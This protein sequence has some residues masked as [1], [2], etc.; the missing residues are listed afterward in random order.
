M[1]NKL[2]NLLGH[3]PDRVIGI[4]IGTGV[5]KLAELENSQG[6]PLLKSYGI[7]DL[8]ENAI[9][10]GRIVDRAAVADALRK[11]ISTSGTSCRDAVL[12][13]SGR[14]LFVREIAMPAMTPVELREAIKWELD[15]YVPYPAESCYF[16]FAILGSGQTETELRI[17]LVIV[18]NERVDE[19]VELVKEVGLRPIAIDIE[20]LAL[21]RTLVAAE[22]SMVIDIGAM[23]SQLIVF[24]GG[25][26]AV[27]RSIPVGG[28]RFTEVVMNVLELEYQEAERLKQ[29][30]A[31]LLQRVDIADDSATLHR[32]LHLLVAEIARE[33]RRT[34]E[35]YQIQNRGSTI[36]R[37]IVTG[38]GVRLNNLAEHLASMLDAEVVVHDPLAG[39]EIA[40]SFD[41]QFTHGNGPQ[42]AVALGLSL[43]GGD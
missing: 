27:T 36:D 16:D 8:A 38:G 41:K 30:Q 11:L 12:A 39:I 20:P 17:L 15:K 1:W 3:K 29:R 18:P 33:V 23:S 43:R 19:L 37:L 2:K 13:V 22:N 7:V 25:S 6:R 40:A 42:L 35:Y 26:P 9:E 34:A 21:Y 24:Q 10:D 14:T 5:V 32:Q 28:R 4:D 31:G